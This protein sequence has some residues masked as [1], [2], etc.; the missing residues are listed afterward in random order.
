LHYDFEGGVIVPPNA[1]VWVANNVASS[2][3]FNLSLRW[4]ETPL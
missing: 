2:F 4:E 1:A 3:T